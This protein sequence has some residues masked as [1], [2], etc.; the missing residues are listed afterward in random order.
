VSTEHKIEWTCTLT[1]PYAF[2]AC[3]GGKCLPFTFTFYLRSRIRKT[4][5][6]SNCSLTDVL[7]R[8]FR[9]TACTD[10][11][12]GTIV[13][14]FLYPCSSVI[15]PSLMCVCVCACVWRL[16]SDRFSHISIETGPFTIFV[17]SGPVWLCY[18]QNWRLPRRAACFRP[19]SAFRDTR[20]PFRRIFLTRD[21][22]KYLEKRTDTD[23]VSVLPDEVF[24]SK[25]TVDLSV[26]K[27]FLRTAQKP[28]SC[29]L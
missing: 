16:C 17:R 6:M 19:F 28:D 29:T 25:L 7:V 2:F 20:R 21:S 4:T 24:I 23:Y 8:V 11:T 1:V 15:C 9:N 18:F 5:F 27:R 13:A 12:V 22:K 3:T 10:I 14:C 26:I